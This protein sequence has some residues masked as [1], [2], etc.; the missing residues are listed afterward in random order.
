MSVESRHVLPDV[1]V[2][3]DHEQVRAEL[4]GDWLAI[5]DYAMDDDCL[6]IVF[7][8]VPGHIPPHARPMLLE[9]LFALPAVQEARTVSATAPIGDVDLLRG[10]TERCRVIGIHAAGSTCL[11][12]GELLSE[13]I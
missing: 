11:I 13:S 2:T 6:T 9:A 12:E 3:A 10:L 1:R 5:A 4:R 7:D 8:V